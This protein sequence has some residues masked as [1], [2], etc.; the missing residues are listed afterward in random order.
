M[1]LDGI[2]VEEV[3]KELEPGQTLTAYV[4]QAVQYSVRR[5]RMRKAAEIYAAALAEDPG[6][7]EEMQ[8]WE[9]ADLA[10]PPKARRKDRPK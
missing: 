9:E 7:G 3:A 8:S 2:L 6:L 5:S 1:K 10:K 4:R